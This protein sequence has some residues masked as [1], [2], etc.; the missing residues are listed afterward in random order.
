MSCF[1]GLA[2]IVPGRSHG[3]AAPPADERPHR[4]TVH[5]IATTDA[6]TRAAMRAARSLGAGLSVAIV[7]IVPHVVPYPLAL[8]PLAAPLDNAIVRAR[9]I[10]DES[11]AAAVNVCVCRPGA[12]NV[13]AALPS[14]ATVVVGTRRGRWRRRAAERLADGLT[15]SGHRVLLVDSDTATK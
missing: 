8:D 13:S 12:E 3:G 15:R 9:E 11:G 7:L 10:A 2:T 1:A 5:V 6:G 4:L 14:G